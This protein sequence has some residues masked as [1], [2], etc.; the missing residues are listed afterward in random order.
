MQSRQQQGIIYAPRADRLPALFALSQ[1]SWRTLAYSKSILLY[2]TLSLSLSLSRFY[3]ISQHISAPFAVDLNCFELQPRLRVERT[4]EWLA[5][6]GAR[7]SDALIPVLPGLCEHPS[8][9]TR[10]AL[11]ACCQALLTEC[12]ES[13]KPMLETLLGMVFTL[14][15]VSTQ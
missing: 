7:V 10:R 1:S 12:R 8:A 4:A 6:T 11:L 9:T 5:S 2:Y 15:Q 3:Y 13:L 14:S